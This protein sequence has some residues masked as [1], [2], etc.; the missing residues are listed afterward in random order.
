MPPVPTHEPRPLRKPGARLGF[1]DDLR[2]Q[3]K[4][5]L[6]PPGINPDVPTA[7][8]YLLIRANATDTGVRP[9]A[10]AVAAHS[11]GIEILDTAR[12]LILTPAAGQSYHLRATVWN[13]GATASYAGLADFYVAPRAEIKVAR[14][15]TRTLPA[16]GHTGF[17]V[18]SGESIV[19][20]SPNVWTPANATEA[21]ESVLVQVADL[22]LDPLGKPFDWIGNRHVALW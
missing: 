7:T 14:A 22:L 16:Q 21:Q 18:R 1:V 15:G 10:G 4:W 11:A 17:V 13:L 5:P 20:E 2:K 3:K 6:E 8:P 9:L 19:V 12:N